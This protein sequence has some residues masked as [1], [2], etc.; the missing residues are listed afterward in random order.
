MD[1]DGSDYGGGCSSDSYDARS[2]CSRGP[3][4]D[5]GEEHDVDSRFHDW[6]DQA[7]M[8]WWSGGEDNR[9]VRKIEAGKEEEEEWGDERLLE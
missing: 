2:I 9:E 6:E 4:W 5:Y 7:E 3:D 8:G 1:M